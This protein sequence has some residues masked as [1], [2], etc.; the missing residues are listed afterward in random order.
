MRHH[1]LVII[2]YWYLIGKVSLCH[3][4]T[5]TILNALE[6]HLVVGTSILLSIIHIHTR[7]HTIVHLLPV[8]IHAT[9]ILIV[10]H[11]LVL[12]LLLVI[13]HVGIVKVGSG[14]TVHILSI[15]ISI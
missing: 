9:S 6:E 12:L 14:T 7:V 4:T 1:T 13:L 10:Y 15:V 3:G 2:L 5:H 11:V 8:W